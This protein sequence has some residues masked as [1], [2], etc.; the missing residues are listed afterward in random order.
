MSKQVFETTL[1]G[2]PLRVVKLPA[3]G[4]TFKRINRRDGTHRDKIQGKPGL[5]TTGA[6]ER[7]GNE[8]RDDAPE[9]IFR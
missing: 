6:D 9:K 7:Q 8:L 3:L 2:K 1:A 4:N 5:R